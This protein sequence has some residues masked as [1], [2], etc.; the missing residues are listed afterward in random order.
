MV[1]FCF[2]CVLHLHLA[3]KRRSLTG[4]GYD[5]LCEHG[6]LS[7][8]RVKNTAVRVSDKQVMKNVGSWNRAKNSRKMLKNVHFLFTC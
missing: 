2:F 7:E 8:S 5:R 6:L 3:E 4:V 1:R